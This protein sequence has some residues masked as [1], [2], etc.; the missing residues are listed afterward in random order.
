MK[1]L[2]EWQT[3]SQHRTYINSD[4]FVYDYVSTCG[5]HVHYN[6]HLNIVE[7]TVP[8]SIVDELIDVNSQ[9]YTF[10]AQS[11]AINYLSL[12]NDVIIT[13]DDNEYTPNMILTPGSHVVKYDFEG[14]DD[15]RAAQTQY[16]INIGT[17]NFNSMPLTFKAIEAGSF[18]WGTS[19]T[20]QYSLDNGSTWTTLSAGEST[21][22]LQPGETIQ[23]KGHVKTYGE[24]YQG[25]N[26]NRFISTGKFDAY[27]NILSMRYN[28]NSKTSL[29][30]KDGSQDGY[31]QCLFRETKIVSA[32]NLK[33]PASSVPFGAYLAMFRGCTELLYA[34]E[35]PAT[36][37][38]DA[39][40]S[41]MFTNCVSLIS[42]PSILP[43]TS[44]GYYSYYAMFSGCSSLEKGPV[45][46]VTQ[47]KN[48]EAEDMF[49][50]CTSLNE[51]SFMAT[52]LTLPPHGLLQGT[53]GG[54]FNKVTG[55][56][57]PRK[58]NNYVVVPDTWTFVDKY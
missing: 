58:Y 12:A 34:P 57:W 2:K 43:A 31:L 8:Q 10:N 53:N 37:I 19:D 14:D 20:V 9:G 3:H 6:P 13:V 15:Y 36:T 55:I 50:N 40:Y 42:A 47:F 23:W 35:L 52:N 56:T 27:G 30:D 39:S 17:A 26:I 54:T 21:P 24:V 45:V 16:I 46:Y 1:Y 18:S 11:F 38:G 51:V 41:G 29:G 7:I 48:D 32:K 33:L 28:F 49:K 5:E 4:Q 25:Q 22:V 44:A